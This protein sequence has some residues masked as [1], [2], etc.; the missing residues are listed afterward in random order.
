MTDERPTRIRPAMPFF[1][2]QRERAT[3]Q[4]ADVLAERRAQ[5]ENDAELKKPA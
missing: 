2:W 5:R 1:W 4:R 3:Q